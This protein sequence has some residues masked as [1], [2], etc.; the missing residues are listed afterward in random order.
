MFYIVSFITLFFFLRIRRPPRFTRTD[1][2]CPSTTLFRST[3]ISCAPG[4]TREEILGLAGSLEQYSRH[5]LAS[6]VVEAATREGLPRL[7]VDEISEPPGQIG[8]AH[9]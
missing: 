3:E 4:F 1:T 8:R 5:P 9:V 6:A 2:L 7:V